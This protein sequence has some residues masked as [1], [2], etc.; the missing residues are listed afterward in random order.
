MMIHSDVW[1]P[2]SVTSLSGFKWFV[3]FID[4]HTR[5][6]WIYMLRGKHEVFRCFQD[7]H[8]LVVNQFNAKIRIIRTD[9]GKEYMNNDFVA[10]LSSHGIIHQTTCPNTPSQNG[11]AERKNRHLLEVARS[12]MF[13]MNVPKYLWS[14]AVLTAAYLINR[15]PSRILDMKSPAELLL[16]QREFKVPP[17]IFGC[18]CFVRDHRPSVGKLDPRAIKCVFV[19]YSSAQKGYKCWDPI[20]KKLFVSMDVTFREFEPY[21]TKPWDLDPLLEEFSSVTESDSREGEN[22]GAAAQKKVIVGGAIPCQMDVSKVQEEVVDQ[23]NVVDMRSGSHE[24]GEIIDGESEEVMVEGGEE[25]IDGTDP[26]LAENRETTSKK[27]IVYQRRRFRSQGEQTIEKEP[28]VYQRRR[29]RSQG[30]QVGTPQP[31]QP[32]LP[33]PNLSSDLSP[34]SS[35]TQSGSSG[36]I[37]PTLKHVDLPLAQ[38][39]DTRSNFGKPLVRYGFEHPT[40]DHD[41]A[42]FLS[43]SRLSPAY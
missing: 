20:G 13:Q 36:N 40:T 43:Y 4:C 21:Y 5:M 11:V 34:L 17:K 30:E 1:G 2:C 38:R 22:E 35:T 10:Y 18:V 37:S 41:I 7:F 32:V 29:F 28:I 16:G 9:N 25:M 6:T 14:E 39:R 27:P 26:C 24:N 3:T 12:L 19:G 23:D 8:N 42:N 33:V 15:M 31:Q